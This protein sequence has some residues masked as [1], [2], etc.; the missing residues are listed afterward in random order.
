MSTAMTLP[1]AEEGLHLDL[2]DVRALEEERR[3]SPRLL[4]ALPAQLLGATQQDAVCC[5]TKDW[6]EGGMYVVAKPGCALAVG[7][8]YELL[9]PPEVATQMPGRVPVDGCF[10]TVVRTEMVSHGDGPA[11]GAGMRFDQPLFF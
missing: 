2:W 10:A 9:F 4:K 1:V 3:A 8:R 7:K 6:S 5:F 11:L